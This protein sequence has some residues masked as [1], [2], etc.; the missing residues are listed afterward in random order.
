MTRTFSQE[1]NQKFTNK[2]LQSTGQRGAA[3]YVN[4]IPSEA[5]DLCTSPEEDINGRHHY[6][7]QTSSRPIKTPL[8]AEDSGAV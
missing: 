4:V 8:N 1:G 5:K 6:R 3:P 7:A 2:Y